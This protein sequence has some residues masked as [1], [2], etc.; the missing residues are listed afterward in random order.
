M[1]E[2]ELKVNKMWN[3]RIFLCYMLENISFDREK[4]TESKRFWNPT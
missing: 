2:N 3:T 4:I 1:P